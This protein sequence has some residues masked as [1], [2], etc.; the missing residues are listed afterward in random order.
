MPSSF[1]HP[2]DELSKVDDGVLDAAAK[3]VKNDGYVAQLP[4][5]LVLAR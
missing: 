1:G 5:P 3:A 4:R 2:A